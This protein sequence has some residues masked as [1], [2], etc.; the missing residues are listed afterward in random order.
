MEKQYYFLAG[1]PRSGNTVLSSILNQNP[2]VYCSPLSP[3]SDFLWN[4]EQVLKISENAKRNFNSGI[5]NVGKNII[6]NYYEDIDKKIIIDRQKAWATSTNLSLI[7]KYV[8][9]NPKIIFTVRPIIEI[10]TSF[11]S[12][13]DEES[14][15]DKEM[16]N[17]GWW[18][19]EYLTKNDN[20]CEY[21]MRQG[22]QID[23][24]LFSLN[25]VLKLNNKNNFYIMEYDKLIENP[26]ETMN[27][28]YNF[29]EISSYE[30]DFDNIIKIKEDVESD[31]EL[32]KNLH[33]VRKKINKVSKNPE[34]VLSQYIINKYSNIG[35]GKI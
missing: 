16:K 6:T 11:I 12:L 1:F 34:Q 24:V 33:T 21:L 7:K 14:Y 35:W 20:R 30:H 17:F 3:I 19:K 26:Q 31:P 22:G 5:M 15:I 2:Q 29:L 9:E 25:E 23:K 28:I 13:L 32:P 27:E 4:Y 18:S 10:L 8:N